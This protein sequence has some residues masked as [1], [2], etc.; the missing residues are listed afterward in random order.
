MANFAAVSNLPG[1]S[2]LVA[3][4]AGRSSSDS[5]KE[6]KDDDSDDKEEKEEEKEDSATRQ[7]SHVG[8]QRFSEEELEQLKKEMAE[9]DQ[10]AVDALNTQRW[11]EAIT[12]WEEVLSLIG[13][14]M[15]VGVGDQMAC[16]IHQNCAKA[17]EKLDSAE[18][19]Q[20]V[21]RHLS[22]AV[23]WAKRGPDRIIECLIRHGFGSFLMR[24]FNRQPLPSNVQHQFLK[25]ALEEFQNTDKVLAEN[26]DS[27]MTTVKEKH[28]PDEADVVDWQMMKIRAQAI[29]QGGQAQV[30][31]GSSSDEHTTLQ[32]RVGLLHGCIDWVPTGAALLMDEERAWHLSEHDAVEDKGVLE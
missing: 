7:K 2:P 22:D 23:T 5:D 1:H 27:I 10:A 17:Y 20:H 25:R 24:A 21:V 12:L 14:Q 26:R 15:E 9:K 32:E 30:M 6:E 29:F 19:D 11:Q 13:D 31:M 16:K 3:P 18:S 28:T 4:V 8:G